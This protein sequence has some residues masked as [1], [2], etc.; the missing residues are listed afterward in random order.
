MTVL[1]MAGGLRRGGWAALLAG[2]LI[3]APVAAHIFIFPWQRAGNAPCE[4]GGGWRVE[5]FW[6]IP[7]GSAAHLLTAENYIV[8]RDP[9]FTFHADYLDWPAGDAA[10][11]PDD[12]LARMGDLLN[13]YISDLSDP[14]ALNLPMRHFLIRATGYFDV[15]LED[16][17]DPFSPPIRKDYGLIAFDGGR[18][19][20]DTTTI[21]RIV[22]PIPPDSFFF[23]DAIY[24]SPG[25]Y[26]IEITYFQRFNPGGTDGTELAGVELRTCQ[27][28][29]FDHP[30]G[31]LMICPDGSLARV[32]P[33][34]L[35]YQFEDVLPELVGD[36]DADNDVDL[37]DFSR[38]QRCFTDSGFE[39]EYDEGCEK[40]DLDLDDDVDLDDY[41]DSFAGFTGAQECNRIGG[42]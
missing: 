31:E 37:F 9:T 30:G 36:F 11:V 4:P 20:I 24:P 26:K 12:A 8:G 6:D 33:P 15:I 38:F 35:I 14:E 18:V 5:C 23:E 3:G 10:N 21:F 7:E 28:D 17:K 27:P 16:A 22:V 39:G 29:G 40:F 13:A 2:A 34:R 19:R 32:T 41:R 42:G 1:R 25:L